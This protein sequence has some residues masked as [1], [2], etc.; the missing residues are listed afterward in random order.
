[1][2]YDGMLWPQNSDS[3]V[4]CPQR[5]VSP[6]WG[7]LVWIDVQSLL[8]PS[9]PSEHD[10]CLSLNFNQLQ[11]IFRCHHQ[12]KKSSIDNDFCIFVIYRKDKKRQNFAWRRSLTAAVRDKMGWPLASSDLHCLFSLWFSP[13]LPC[14]PVHQKPSL[15]KE[16][17]EI[18]TVLFFAKNERWR[19][20]KDCLVNLSQITA[21]A[22]R[23]K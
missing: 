17:R 8:P 13:R 9:W 18:N 7:P 20:S 3:V 21:L 19:I 14:S 4:W 12:R 1:M 22:T 6:H 15:R 2:E 16:R 23:S 5:P 11:Q 10:K